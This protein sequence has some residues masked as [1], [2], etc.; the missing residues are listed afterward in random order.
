MGDT[1]DVLPPSGIPYDVKCISLTN[2]YGQSVE[3]A[4]HPMQKLTIKSDKA[5]EKG[6]V[7]RKKKEF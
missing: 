6:S 1:L 5:I 3:A 4:P 7:I 2:E